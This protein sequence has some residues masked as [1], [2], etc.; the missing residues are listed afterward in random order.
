MDV[1]DDSKVC[2]VCGKK[3]TKKKLLSSF[4]NHKNEKNSDA[5]KLNVSNETKIKIVAAVVVT[6]VIILVVILIVNRIED[7]T[8]INLAKDI[9]DFTGEPLKTAINET[10]NY[11]ADESAYDSVNFLTSFDYVI[12]DE[13]NLKID[14]VKYPEWVV[15]ITTDDNDKITEVK[16]VDFTILKKNSK[17]TKI[18][19]EINLD[20]FTAG[21]K[22]RKVV[23]D[24]DAEPFSITYSDGSVTYNYKY[25]FVNDVKD[26]QA[27]S[28]DVVC[29]LEDSY[30]YSTTRR[31]TPEWLK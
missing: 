25:Y 31:Q 26:E 4:R 27:M 13:D 14:G 10:Q 30:I 17:G 15:L 20:K 3:L 9:K 16:Y 11:F 24:I 22:L 8:G 23:K 7:N 18:K 28:L 29:D 1:P 12:E 5:K 2:E 19:S 6:A 21:D